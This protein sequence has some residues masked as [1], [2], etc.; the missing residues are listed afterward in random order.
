MHKKFAHKSFILLKP[1]LHGRYNSIN[2][3]KVG[4]ELANL[5]SDPDERSAAADALE[6]IATSLRNTSLRKY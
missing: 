1:L 3:K 6:A 2:L 5:I 4:R